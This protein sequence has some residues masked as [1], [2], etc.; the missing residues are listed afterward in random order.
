MRFGVCR[1]YTDAAFVK[2]CGYD[3]IEPALCE[4]AAM[5]EEE[6]TDCKATLEQ[7]GIKAEV[8][9]RFFPDE[10]VL[11]GPGTDLGKILTYVDKAV[12]RAHEL[13]AEMLVLD[14]G[15]NRRI[16]DDWDRDTCVAQFVELV[17]MIGKKMDAYGMR[18]V[19]EPLNDRE[20]NFINTVPEGAE[21]ANRV[22]RPN[23]KTMVNFFHHS[24]VGGEPY[25]IHWVKGQVG[26]LHV[27]RNSPDHL[28]PYEEDMDDVRA[29]ALVMNEI[30]YNDRLS[31]EG[32]FV[33]FKADA[34]AAL[35]RVREFDYI[36]DRKEV[37]EDLVT[38]T[39]HTLAGKL[40]NPFIMDD[41]TPVKTKEDWT[42]RRAEIYKT[43]VEL[44]YGTMPPKPE[45]L[46]VLCTGNADPVCNYLI[47]TGTK[48]NPV[49]M[50]MTVMKPEGN[51]PFPVAVDGD[52][53]FR[54]P[55]DQ[56]F[57][58]TFLDN[59]IALALFN[60]TMLMP[61]RQDMGRVG[62]LVE[63]YPTYNFGAI[64]A[65]AW[66]YSRC[67]DAL[68]TLPFID[69]SCMAAVGH[70]RGGKTA[71]LAGACDERF[72]IVNPNEGC[73][74]S[75]SCYRLRV[76]AIREDKQTAVSE[77]LEDMFK[78]FPLWFNPALKEY[79]GRE[80]DLPFD[81]HYLKALVAPRVLLDGEAASDIWGNPIGSWHTTMAA[82]EVFKF[83]GAEDNLYWYNRRGYHYHKIEDVERLVN[84]IRHVY[85][86]TALKDGFFTLPFAAPDPI[87]DWKCP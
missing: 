75:T 83:L 61:D 40:P 28:I 72:A 58:R 8:C 39:E 46:E 50:Q 64:A 56:K 25:Q 80:E 86:G 69:K 11:V 3:Y 55:W 52:L 14:N 84:V 79:I 9:N 21:L 60:R 7:A 23:V 15:A 37:T 81:S 27:A 78:N 29:W 36:H 76:K 24:Q 18:L 22:S 6:F 49:Y 10:Y 74:G 51:G 13:G 44:Q 73:A 59:G 1:P 71:L 82:G 87:Y 53:C 5:T 70:S 67:V 19:I 35:E 42:H 68:E 65:W 12:V 66:G 20:T 85:D 45:I 77:Q 17:R 26:Y 63:A 31:L 43:A 54:Y 33:N 38:V 2:N 41:G 32:T 47:K 34:K 30:G 48:A 4:I 16:Q 57:I 62:P